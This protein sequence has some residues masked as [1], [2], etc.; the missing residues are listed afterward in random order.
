M[1]AV[2]ASG[3]EG[4][5][6]KHCTAWVTRL[7][8]CLK[9]HPHTYRQDTKEVVVLGMPK[10]STGDWLREKPSYFLLVW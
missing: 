10:A 5:Q 4:L 6:G 1:P 9:T 2:P 3:V 7:A 8:W